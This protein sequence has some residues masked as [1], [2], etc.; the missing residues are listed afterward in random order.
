MREQQ[1][2]RRRR[3]E[4]DEEGVRTGRGLRLRTAC[5]ITCALPTQVKWWALLP[6]LH[7]GQI[8]TGYIHHSGLYCSSDARCSGYE[9]IVAP[10]GGEDAAA[11]KICFT[12]P[13]RSSSRLRKQSEDWLNI[14]W[15]LFARPKRIKLIYCTLLILHTARCGN[16]LSLMMELSSLL[17]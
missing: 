1:R 16:F 14:S 5:P 6:S 4:R 7:W 17:F 9:I 3:S 11:T 13:W 12:Q 15:S 2:R 10:T 8:D